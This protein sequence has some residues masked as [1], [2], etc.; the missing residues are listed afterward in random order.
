MRRAGLVNDRQRVHQAR[1]DSDVADGTR[2]HA[3][4]STGRIRASFVRSEQEPAEPGE[5]DH[6]WDTSSRTITTASFVTK[7]AR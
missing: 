2:D 1:A 7:D 3:D 5:S 4:L 6:E